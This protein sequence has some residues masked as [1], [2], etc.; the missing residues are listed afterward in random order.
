MSRIW[1]RTSGSNTMNS[2]TRLTNSGL[3][4]DQRRRCQD[5]IAVSEG[6]KTTELIKGNANKYLST[7]SFRP[8]R[9]VENN[10]LGGSDQ[11]PFTR[12]VMMLIELHHALWDSPASA[13]LS[14]FKALH[15]PYRVAA[16]RTRIYG[17]LPLQKGP[18]VTLT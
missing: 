10:D 16:L 7:R 9:L 5:N 12:P 4:A 11:K 15:G 17:A 13:H 14:P 8:A 3:H 2:S 18:E 1:L 6:G